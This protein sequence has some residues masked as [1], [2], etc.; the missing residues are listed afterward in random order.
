MEQMIRPNHGVW[1]S[2]EDNVPVESLN[3]VE[4]N[5]AGSLPVNVPGHTVA[6]TDGF[7]SLGS[8]LWTSARVPD[9]RD[10]PNGWKEAGQ[11]H[12]VKHCEN[13][14]ENETRLSEGSGELSEFSFKDDVHGG[15]IAGRESIARDT[16]PS[17]MSLSPDHSASSLYC[18]EDA[19]DVVHWDAETWIPHLPTAADSGAG[20]NSSIER[21]LASELHHM[22]ESDYVQRLRDGSVDVHKYYHFRPV[23]A[24]LSVNYLDRFLS[25]RALPEGNG[26]PFQL[27]SVACLSLAAKMEETSVPLLLDLQMFVP[28]FLFEPRTVQRMELLIM[29]SLKWRMSSV[30]PFDFIDYFAAKLQCFGSRYALSSRVFSSA[31]DLILSTGRVIEFLV[32]RPSTV[33][34]AAVLIATGESVDFLAGDDRFSFYER[35]NKEM[36][37]GCH[38][39]MDEY[40]VDTRPT[41]RLKHRRTEPPPPSPVGVLEAAACG[42]CDTQKSASEN[43]ESSQP[44]PSN[45]RSKS[46]AT[47]IQQQ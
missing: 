31:S 20:D 25:T 18:S 23:T 45:K 27:L 38:Q 46:A 32:H 39:L 30:T 22:P 8:N 5:W 44:E 26:W 13:G 43:P 40:L 10:G 11:G 7:S 29:D 19:G 3:L 34:A 21:L 16:Y 9:T 4:D 1:T 37:R 24:Y 14:K 35:V 42:S 33:A 47:D 28:R 2:K 15:R 36:V 12:D 17:T 41:A 6:A